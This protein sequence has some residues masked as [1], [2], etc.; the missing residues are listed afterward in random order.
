MSE[1][2]YIQHYHSTTPGNVPSAED[3]LVGEIAIN[4]ADE[5]IFFKNI[6]DEVITLGA[7]S[8]DYVS[9]T[10]DELVSLRNDSALE[11]GKHY[12]IND[13]AV[14]LSDEAI[15]NGFSCTDTSFSILTLAVSPNQIAERAHIVEFN[16]NILY[17]LDVD[18]EKYWYLS[19]S[20]KGVIYY[21]ADE[22]GN[23]AQFDFKSI[24]KNNALLFENCK[25]C[26][27]TGDLTYNWNF[28]KDSTDVNIIF[29][30]DN[31]VINSAEVIVNNCSSVNLN[32]AFKVELINS[33]GITWELSSGNENVQLGNRLVWY[34]T[35]INCSDISLTD[36]IMFLS[37]N[38]C[39]S[40]AL[41]GGLNGG[42]LNY[43]TLNNCIGTTVGSGYSEDGSTI[44]NDSGSRF[45]D[46]SGFYSNNT[47]DC[48]I[49]GAWR[50]TVANCYKL[51]V[52]I[53]GGM[54]YLTY[55]TFKH[56]Y[57]FNVTGSAQRSCDFKNIYNG[58]NFNL[59]N[60]TFSSATIS[61]DSNKEIQI[62]NEADLLNQDILNP[63]F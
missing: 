6:D 50:T 27:I 24:A 63:T 5:K 11:P 19:E 14:I 60:V 22:N 33:A 12:L 29:G 2:K 15:N 53:S 28:I 54:S 21:M 23:T 20:A 57:N 47:Y 8:A 48:D 26:K 16:C 31:I 59:Q 41:Y 61:Q 17:T 13:Y 25:N 39:I 30:E 9:L 38:N 51:T 10:Y 42:R 55:R 3:L 4:A 56:C 58:G 45:I 35:I 18:T 40:C 36:H 32:A 34:S 37:L 1:R 49:T 43:F 62:Y 46:V 52:N 44:N 7:G